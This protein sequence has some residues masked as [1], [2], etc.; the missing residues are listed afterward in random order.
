MFS[1][2]SVEF[3]SLL[4]SKNSNLPN[5]CGKKRQFAVVTL[6][7]RA[8]TYTIKVGSHWVFF[9]IR[10]VRFQK[11]FDPD[12]GAYVTS[13]QLKKNWLAELQQSKFVH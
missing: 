3:I 12:F 9:R 6:L 5:Y 1:A 7:T 4:L 11:P 13:Y 2:N 10:Y 8:L